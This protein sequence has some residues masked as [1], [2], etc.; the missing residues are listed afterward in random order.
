MGL[1][2][3]T[4][5]CYFQYTKMGSNNN[6]TPDGLSIMDKYVQIAVNKLHWL[7]YFNN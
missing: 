3:L 6:D 1:Y 5:D 2:S 4:G 7:K